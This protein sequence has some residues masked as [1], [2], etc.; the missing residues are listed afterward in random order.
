MQ[1]DLILREEHRPDATF[2]VNIENVPEFDIDLGY[3]TNYWHRQNGVAPDVEPFETQVFVQL[4][5]ASPRVL[6]IGANV[7]W[8]SCIASAA[9]GGRARAHAFEP[10]HNNFTLL[11]R[12]IGL[13]G[14]HGVWPHHVAL[15][16]VD[17]R[18]A[19]FLNTENCGD[20]RIGDPGGRES[21]EVR[22]AKL[23]TVLTHQH[24]IPDLVKI[25]VQGAE[26]QVFD[27]ATETFRKAGRS[28]AMCVE[29]FPE[30]L[31]LDAAHALADR[32][33]AFGRPVYMLHPQ[34]GNQLQPLNPEVL[35]E[36]VEGCLHPRFGRY[37]DILIAPDDARTEKLR[38]WLGRDW[39]P[40]AY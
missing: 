32:I 18:G 36:A 30:G 21:V 9:S 40:W 28:L 22:V 1:S 12:N 39:A 27:G 33:F 31:G 37:G 17:A 2:R 10:E 34:E 6:D 26:L 15:G 3:R 11:G 24:F 4:L 13:N 35:H 23:D 7:G 8:Y 16:A 5:S 29:F 14:F 20:H 25:D 38:H 19:L